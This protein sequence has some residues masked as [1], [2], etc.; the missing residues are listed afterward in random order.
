MRPSMR[1]L[2]LLLLPLLLLP[3]LALHARAEGPWVAT[4]TS[5]GGSSNALLSKGTRYTL[6]CTAPARYVTGNGSGTVA[7]ANATDGG[8]AYGFL[9]DTAFRDFK[10]FETQAN[11]D[12]LAIIP[13]PAASVACY[14]FKR[15]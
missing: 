3:W 1:K 4:L 7:S 10:D 6:Q 12:Y 2:P 13:D 5:D 9:Y 8:T 15:E 11:S 14:V